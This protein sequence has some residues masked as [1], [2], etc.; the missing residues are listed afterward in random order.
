M[1]ICGVCLSLFFFDVY[2]LHVNSHVG[3]NMMQILEAR[4]WLPVLIGYL[5]SWFIKHGVCDPM[6]GSSS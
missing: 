4:D 5:N 2:C 3:C 6:K 1:K